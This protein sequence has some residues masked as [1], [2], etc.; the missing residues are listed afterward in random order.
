MTAQTEARVWFPIGKTSRDGQCR[1]VWGQRPLSSVRDIQLLPRPP[2]S[3][4]EW[5]IRSGSAHAGGA[6]WRVGRERLSFGFIEG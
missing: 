6:K 3:G 4:P 1:V 5:T 2:A